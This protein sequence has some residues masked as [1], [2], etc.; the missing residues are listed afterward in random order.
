[1]KFLRNL[2]AT[3]TG[4]F[5]FSL[6]AILFIMGI[7]AVATTEDEVVV[8]ENSVLH[9][10]LNKPVGERAY[11]DP[12]N[13]LFTQSSSN[14]G[15]I[16][17]IAS[18]QDAKEND[19]IK[20]IY[21]ES[22]IP[23]AGFASLEAIRNALNDFKTSGKFITCYSEIYTEGGYYLA[24]TAD[25]IY[26]NPRGY[27]EF[28]GIGAK[29][30]FLKGMFDK[31]EIEPE[32]FRVG[33]FKS[34]V[35]PFIRKDMSPENRAQ[36]ESLLSSIYDHFLDKVAD[37][38]SIPMEKLTLMSDSM[39][40]RNPKQALEN[41]LVTG[42]KYFDEVLDELKSKL[43]LEE[44]DKIN[45]IGFENYHK[46]ISNK[47][48]SKNR[49]AVIIG[50]GE[51]M[52]G[53]GDNSTIGSTSFAKE[54]RK[55]RK[56]D[57]VKAVVVR[58]NSPGGSALASDVIWREIMLTKEVKP[59]I[60]SLSDYAASGGYYITMGCD[61]I[62]AEPSTI[63]GSIGIF[64]TMFNLGNFMEN[65]LGLTT[66]AV[67]TGVYTDLYTFTRSLSEGERHIIQTSVNEGYED[68]VTKAAN[69]R[70]MSVEDLKKVASGRVWSGTQA[71]ENG[72][73]DKIGGLEEAI[74]LAVEAADI[75]ED[76]KIKYYPRQKSFIEQVREEF[77]NDLESKFLKYKTGELY[78]LIKQIKSLENLKGIQ[79]RMLYDITLE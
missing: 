44:D 64:L 60:A 23:I 11:Q 28:N 40:V 50:S 20:G 74:G 8:K 55:A 77:S 53:N 76:Y 42:L 26:V 38:R 24:S 70:N 3:L 33:D 30:T 22:G 32:I 35:E 12:F 25:D 47:N 18:I 19:K 79:A 65:K 43:E 68:F 17:L 66:D 37:S 27:F 78:P 45:F 59:V 69:N 1:M 4:L 49:V 14:I 54:I 9:I 15:L 52:G 10:K 41:E 58:V 57:K 13:E 71:L 7:V 73:V 63:T 72:L 46:S 31:L 67:N 62:V 61:A 2:L 21:L 51:I 29:I 48:T 36:L 6:I 34:A 5:I 75:A 56:D 39:K 16:E